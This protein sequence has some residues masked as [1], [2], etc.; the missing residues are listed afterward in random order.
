[1]NVLALEP[2]YGGSHQAFLEHWIGGSRHHWTRLSLPAH[3]WKWRMRHAS[4]TLAAQAEQLHREGAR[5]DLVFC[6][7]MLSLAEWKGLSP[8]LAALPAVAYFHE[9]QLTYPVRHTN[10]RDFHFAMSN[11]TTMI[12]ASQSPA[13]PSSR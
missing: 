6:S 10:E 8:S 12:A 9:N 3:H 1:M 2:Y 5:W 4:V 7:D 11:V 13:T